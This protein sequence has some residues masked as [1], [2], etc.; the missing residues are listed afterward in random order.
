MQKGDFVGLCRL[1]RRDLDDMVKAR[2]PM[3]RCVTGRD[4]GESVA[5]MDARSTISATSSRNTAKAAD[6]AAERL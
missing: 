1:L 5:Q 3:A 6:D 2:E 4:R